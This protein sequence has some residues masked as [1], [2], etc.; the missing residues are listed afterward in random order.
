MAP[1]H[2]GVAEFQLALTVEES[3]SGDEGKPRGEEEADPVDAEIV[4]ERVGPTSEVH[5]VSEL[6]ETTY[7]F[8]QAPYPTPEDLAKY[9]EIHPGFTDRILT[10]TERET[11]HRIGRDLLRD[12]AT[13]ALARRGQ[14]F[15]F[16]FVMALVLGGVAAILTGHSV[17]G[18]AG[19]IIAATALTGAFVA[20]NLFSSH[21]DAPPRPGTEIEQRPG[22]PSDGEGDQA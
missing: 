6:I 9:E 4:G 5:Y 16:V 17:A 22:E 3:S 7:S 21:T 18:L 12:R 14:L 13:I 10:L 11:D 20:P 19:L 1:G 2:V 8:R 15:A